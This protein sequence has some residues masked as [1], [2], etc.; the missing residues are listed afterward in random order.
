VV[1]LITAPIS[2]ERLIDRAFEKIRQA[3][4]GMP[5]VI[6]R[7]LDALVAITRST[8][9]P[10]RLRVLLAQGRMIHRLAL[11]TV[12]EPTDMADVNAVYRELLA[13]HGGGQD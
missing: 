1:R 2:Y 4:G 13:L 11:E 6:I 7:E 12:A 3:S 8:Q 5:A 10:E 9:R